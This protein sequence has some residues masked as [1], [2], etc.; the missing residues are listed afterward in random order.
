MLFA[1][2]ALGVL[3]GPARAQNSTWNN[4]GT[5]WNTTGDWTGGT[6]TSANTAQF[7]ST[8]TNQPNLAAPATVGGIWATTG[9]GQ[10]VTVSGTGLLT[11][12]GS[13]TA[14]AGPGGLANVGILLDDTANHNL[15][16]SAPVDLTH[17]SSFLVNNTGTLTLSGG[18]TLANG[19]ILTLGSN[20]TSGAGN[21]SISNIAATTAALIINDAN[22][23]TAEG[24]TIVTLSGTN[25]YSGGT[26]LGNQNAANTGGTLN[27]NSSSAIGTGTLTIQQTKSI[28]D[29]TSGAAVTLSTNNAVVF[30]SSFTFGGTNNLNLGTG[31][32]N[33]QSKT[34][35]ITLD[36][37]NS[38]LTMGTMT[39]TQPVSQG[40]SDTLTVS[41]GGSGS[42]N[43]LVLAAYSLG[44]DTTA[45]KSVVFQG[46]A[47]I[48]INGGVS[49]D[50]FGGGGLTYNGTGTL[51]IGGT[52]NYTGATLVEGAGAGSSTVVLNNATLGATAIT[53]G[54]AD[55][56]NERGTLVIQGNTTIGNSSG[57]SLTVAIGGS[58]IQG[59]TL[60]LV[61][62]GTIN[63]LT[64]GNTSGTTFTI[65][66]NAGRTSTLD[67]AV[68]LGSASEIVLQSGAQ[69]S[70]NGL[71][72]SGGGIMVNLTGLG[73]LTGG[74]QTLISA[75]GGVASG[76]ASF[77]S[78]S[79]KLN[80]S[81]GNF[82]GYT[83]ALGF[84]TTSLTLTETVNAAAANA[85]WNGAASLVTAQGGTTAWN[86]FVNGN[87]DT[88]NFGTGAGGTGNANGLVGSTTNVF[89]DSGVTSPVS[90]TLGQNL[91]VNSLNFSSSQAVSIG[92]NTLTIEAT[93][94]NG[95]IVGDGINVATGAASDT[96][97]SNVA[98]GN[99]QTWTVTDASNT[100][101]VSGQV[102]GSSALTT[103]GAGSVALT[104]VSGNTYTGGTTVSSGTLYADNTTSGSATG[105]G[106]VSVASG[107]TLAGTG[108]ITPVVSSGAAVSVS[109]GGLIM[110][111]GVQ[112]GSTANGN[113]TLD[114]TNVTGGSPLLSVASSV[115]ATT[116]SLTFTLGAGGSATGEN[117]SGSKI[118]VGGSASN[119]IN[120]NSNGGSGTIVS[121][122]DLVGGGL[123]L[124]QD[125]VLIKGNGSTTFEIDGQELSIG[126]A[127]GLVSADGQ[128][129]GGLALLA[130]NTPGNF[131]A[132]WYGSSELFLVGDNI[133]V[134]VIPEP[135]TWTMMFGG[136]A[137]LVVYQRRKS[138]LS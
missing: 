21:I 47:N 67:M 96:V 18:L 49:D 92:G 123:T 32:V 102:S 68:G 85:F 61:A 33:M 14:T 69:I 40:T 84:T 55:Q 137:L 34:S 57:G 107:G 63:T 125:Y 116:P 109:T 65:D 97:S 36:G 128:I 91:T 3:A 135:G 138:K 50:P 20:E 59:G 99:N 60:S 17:S 53:I 48:T 58:A 27:I 46:T 117:L 122:N 15:T 70:F 75:P 120:F 77:S 45:A 89:F 29:N 127:D 103:A 25:N 24:T 23:T 82:S 41:N 22:G 71:I 113:L 11:L 100:L 73:G 80:S 66:N 104:D 114:P 136:F 87:T 5:D 31:A 98:L 44:T 62:G 12:T 1:V 106:A 28:I 132:D 76:S 8:F 64:L 119:I 16:I 42:G 90:T 72:S 124:N 93:N 118:M 126:N 6:P 13:L 74:T 26:T 9:L 83:V 108:S 2:T 111:G 131:F 35:A 110:P 30:Q 43:T 7:S 79:F 56:N 112:S 86:S 95:N 94:A 39:Q 133:D 51:T 115:N 4:A 52:S 37:T 78:S 88:S 130:A 129:T 121:I 10:D 101:T 134:E 19:T 54:Q 105:T 38:T 81:T